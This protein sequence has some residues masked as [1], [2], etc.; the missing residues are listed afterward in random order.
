MEPRHRVLTASPWGSDVSRVAQGFSPAHASGNGGVRRFVP[1]NVMTSVATSPDSGGLA[2]ELFER[3]RGA[4]RAYLR[5]VTGNPEVADDLAQDV[6][7]RVVQRGSAYEP[8]GRERAWLFSIAR[9]LVV[10][11]FRR[12][13]DREVALV[14]VARPATQAIAV[15]V[16][17]AIGKLPERER[18]AFL[19]C[20]VG[21]LS[22]AE[23]AEATATTGAGVR[24]AIYRARMQLRRDV[25][26]P[27]PVMPVRAV[28]GETDDEP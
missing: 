26:V 14:D 23:I 27:P 11:Y 16:R 18:E 6:Y 9:H 7:L 5:L 13:R 22:Y 2:V 1:S 8:R 3:H 21:G 25:L 20:E 24:S 28:A 19:L 10:D 12:H 4:L 15:S 17:A